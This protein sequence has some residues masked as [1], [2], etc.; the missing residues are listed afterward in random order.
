HFSGREYELTIHVISPFHEH[1][2]NKTILLG[3]TL[4]RDELLVILPSSD[5]LMRD[6]MLYKQTDKY[7]RQN[8]STTQQESKR[9]ILTDKQ[10]QNQERYTHLR[11]LV[12]DLLTEAELIVA[13]QTLDEGGRDPKS[14]LVRG[15]YTLI[16][17]TYPNLQML[18]GVAYREDHIAQHLKPATTLLGD[19][20][21][22]YSEAE[23]EMLNFVNTNHRNGV[24]T[25][26]RTLTEKFEHKPYGWYLAAVQCILAKLCARGKIEL[27]QDSYLLEEGALERAIRNTRDASNIIL[28][29]Q[30]EFTAV[31]V[32]QLRDFHADF[33]STPPHANEAKA[34]AQETADSFR[35]Q[36]QTLTDLRR[37]ATHYPFLTALDKPLDALKSVV[38]QPYTFY[39]TELRQQEDQ[40][41]D[42]KE[43][44]IDPILT[45]MNGSQKEI[46][47]E[48]RQLLQ[49][50][51]ANFSYVG[52]GKAQQLRQLLDDPHCY[53]GN[54][55]QQAKALGDELQTAVSTR[56]QQEREATLARIDNLWRWLTKMTEYGQLTTK[57]QQMLQQPFLAI[58]QKIER[59]QLI[60][61][62]HGQLRRFENREYTEQLEQMM[63][64]AQQPPTSPSANAEPTERTVAEPAIT[65]E[66]VK[67]DT[68][69]VPFDKAL[70]TTA[71]DVDAYV[72]KLRQ[73]LLDAL[74]DG[75]QI[76]V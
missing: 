30:I 26:L 9:R 46:Y 70:L 62:I 40:L 59:Q 50:Q 33:F 18:R 61:V 13:G 55:M 66:I 71:A 42:L 2:G 45:F 27:R 31:Q 15:F 8:T 24:R 1:T 20:P 48:T 74:N 6:L 29:P 11:T 68:L 21:A 19:T 7:T 56:L 65:Y 75:K 49:V 5:R 44:V 36:Q 4:G 38:R 57:Q 23:R 17:R 73:T 39:L 69:A 12:S 58:K 54:K 35:N 67:R 47:D 10:F 43:D 14:R 41:L 63:N 64:W 51:E 34:L 52:Q 72:E 25:T 60:D 37:Q 53:Q 28:D 32:R 3:Q 22:S 16:E 76:Q